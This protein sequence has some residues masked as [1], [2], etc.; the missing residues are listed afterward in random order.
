MVPGCVVE[1]DPVVTVTENSEA[2]WLF[3]KVEKPVDF[4]ALMTYDMADGW[5]S[6]TDVSG[7]FCRKVESAETA[8]GFSV[9]K[10]DEVTVKD[11]VTKEQMDALTN[12]GSY[13]TLT[14]TAYAV[15]LYKTNGTE[16]TAAEAWATVYAAS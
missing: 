2:C 5:T 16:F 12:A 1:K 3:V 8:Q 10:N 13:P 14:F 6:L 4:D 15:Q 7:V 11:T 9:L